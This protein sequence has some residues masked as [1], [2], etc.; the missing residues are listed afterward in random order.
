MGHVGPKNGRR[1]IHVSKSIPN[2]SIFS[3]AVAMNIKVTAFILTCLVSV[4]SS[5]CHA[6]SSSVTNLGDGINLADIGIDPLTDE[7]VFIGSE[8]EAGA[9]V[10]KVFRL[11]SDRATLS[12][13]TL[14]GLGPN[15]VAT[16]ISPDGF[17]ISGHSESPASISSLGEGTTWLVDSPD[18]PTGVGFAD[19]L[20]RISP[21]SA[22]WN[23]G[24]VGTDG[25]GANAYGWTP[26]GGVDLLPDSSSGSFGFG[27]SGD[28]SLTVGTSTL[29]GATDGAAFWD[30]SGINELDD[31]FGISSVANAVSPNAEFIG[32]EVD[33]FD[34]ATFETGTQAAVWSSVD[35]IFGLELLTIE[36]PETMMLERL[37]GTVHDVSLSGFAVGETLD[38][39][40]FIWHESFNGIDSEFLGAQIFDDFL[41]E[42]EGLTLDSFSRSVVGIAEDGSGDLHFAVNGSAFIVSDVQFSTNGVPEPSSTVLL[43]LGSIPLLLKRRRRWDASATHAKPGVYRC[44]GPASNFTFVTRLIC[45]FVIL[46]TAVCFCSDAQ[47]QNRSGVIIDFTDVFSSDFELVDLGLRPDGGLNVI[48][49]G[50][51]ASGVNAPQLIDVAPDRLSFSSS[52]LIGVRDTTEVFGISS[53]GSRVAGVSTFVN[54]AETEATT[55]LSSSPS[56]YSEIG[57]CK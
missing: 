24:V 31:P 17:R 1:T 42:T 28:G 21:S 48:G 51:N 54:P 44:D 27:V 43:M 45:I 36:D 30:A 23:G 25:G 35:T 14:V 56:E 41:F 38:G 18:S 55:W 15:T 29:F 26:E 16:G 10:A 20:V 57:K 7:L 47:A 50:S 40:G 37:L 3:L 22:A 4:Y 49:N 8:E 34:A 6:Q 33:F 12:S 19:P 32:G 13:E 11:S 52:E 5:D 46:A 2:N 53:D 9:D 39:Q